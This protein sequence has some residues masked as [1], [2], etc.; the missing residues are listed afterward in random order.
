MLD[1]I[2]TRVLRSNETSLP[3][4]DMVVVVATGASDDDAT[5][6]AARMRD[7]GG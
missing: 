3:T 6:S 5:E 1:F 2:R 4:R 7:D